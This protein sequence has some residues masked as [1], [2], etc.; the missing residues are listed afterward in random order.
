VFNVV[1][2]VLPAAHIERVLRDFYAGKFGNEDLEERLLRNV[3][4]NHFRSICHNALEGLASRKLNLEMLIERRALAQE[5]RMV[6]ESIARFIT[7][8][9]ELTKLQLKPVSN[10][11]HTFEPGRTPPVLK[12]YERQANWRLP[13][14]ASRYPRFSTDRVTAET[15]RLEWVTPGHPLFESLRRHAAAQAEVSL[16]SGACY[17]TLNR[18]KASRLD[19]YRA[20]VV[21]G[22][23]RIIHE[24]LFAIELSEDGFAQLRDPSLIGDLV[25]APDAPDPLPSVITLP[26]GSHALDDLALAPFLEEVKLI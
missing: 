1:G 21:D 17:Y 25:P 5:R 18:E 7:E 8:A 15:N 6:P 20:R 19:F 12:S 10:L 2:E 16:S 23:G 26:E 14:V 22:L 3:D 24:R 13:Q 4:E 9:A 11:I